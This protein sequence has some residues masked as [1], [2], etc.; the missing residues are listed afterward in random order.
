[1]SSSIKM[2]WLQVGNNLL[3]PLKDTRPYYIVSPLYSYGSA[4]IR[5]LYLLCHALNRSGF[6]A[7]MVNYPF[8]KQR[9]STVNSELWAP[10]LDQEQLLVHFEQGQTPIVIYPEIVSGNP[11][12]APIVARWILNFPGLLGGDSTY[13]SREI[14]FG[15]SRELASAGG[16]PENVLQ[17][18]TVDTRIFYPSEIELDRRG[19]CFYAFKYQRIHKG[20]L[21]P[22]L[23]DVLKLLGTYLIR[24]LRESWP[25]YY[26]VR[27]CSIP[28]KIQ[29]WSRKQFSAVVRPYSFQILT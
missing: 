8:T 10:M 9:P 23:M 20:V 19:G 1:M 22:S 16:N 2:P 12:K 11:L 17:I 3:Y 29:H 28:M 24:S 18:P 21:A 26:G 6:Q 27:R 14:C 25:N 7:Y 15:Y 4:G 13:D 5:A